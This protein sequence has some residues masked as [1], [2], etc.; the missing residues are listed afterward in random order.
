MRRPIPVILTVLVALAIIAAPALG[1][2]LGSVDHRVLPPSAG[3]HQAAEDINTNFPGIDQQPVT[4]LVEGVSNPPQDYINAVEKVDGI[5]TV[6]V[7]GVAEDSVYM[8]AHLSNDWQ[9]AE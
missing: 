3:V 8:Q 2:R 5:D 9:S 1:L 6:E 7:M 4:V